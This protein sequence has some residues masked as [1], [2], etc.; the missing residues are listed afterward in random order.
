MN[1]KEKGPRSSQQLKR[2]VKQSFAIEGYSLAYLRQILDA[3]Q[4]LPLFY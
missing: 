2:I 1:P 4:N 3:D